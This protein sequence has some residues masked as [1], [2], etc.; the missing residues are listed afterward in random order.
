MTGHKV[1]DW[2]QLTDAEVMALSGKVLGWADRRRF[3]CRA[4]Q[5]CSVPSLHS[6]QPPGTYGCRPLW[7]YS[8]RRGMVPCLLFL[9]ISWFLPLPPPD[10]RIRDVTTESPP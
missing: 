3:G 1:S 5:S 4:R 2:D 7:Q 9:R 10:W 8:G 6:R